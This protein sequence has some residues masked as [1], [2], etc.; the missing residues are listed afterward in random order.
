MRLPGVLTWTQGCDRTAVGVDD[1]ASERAR[2]RVNS[3]QNP[4][5]IIIILTDI[6]NAVSVEVRL[7]RV[8]DDWAVV[9][10]VRNPVVVIII[11]TSIANVVCVDVR[12]VRIDDDWAVVNCVQN[13]IVVIIAVTGFSTKGAG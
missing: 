7:A 11:V 4:V 3:V 1:L 6:A 2:A 12:L 9:N 13:P 8:S 5:V 10:S